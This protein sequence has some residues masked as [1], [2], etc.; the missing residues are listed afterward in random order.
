MGKKPRSPRLPWEANPDVPDYPR[1]QTQVAPEHWCEQRAKGKLGRRHA[2]SRCKPDRVSGWY[3][4]PHATNYIL[5]MQFG[6]KMIVLI[7][8]DMNYVALFPF[9]MN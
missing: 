1:E 7:P 2:A 6:I 3:L 4:H 5:V 8:F 9:D